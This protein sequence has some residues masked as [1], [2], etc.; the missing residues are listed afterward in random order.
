L[1]KKDDHQVKKLKGFL[2]QATSYTQWAEIAQNLD[3]IEKKDH[4]KSDP[5]SDIYNHE[6]LSARLHE[7][8]NFRLAGQIEDLSR[9]LREGLHHDLGNMGDS[10]LYQECYLGT[11]H[12]IDDYVAEVC[13]CLTYV[14]NNHKSTM[15]PAQK[16]D[17]FKTILLSFGRPALLMSGGASLG[18]FH[19][20]VV[21]ALW[22]RDLLPQVIAG[23]S[24][25]SII[26]AALGT[27]TDDEL[28]E[29]FDP[30]Q[31]SLKPWKW[32]GIASGLSGRGF[33]DQQQLKETIRNFIGDY[34]M[35]EAF[36]RTG[37]SINITVSPVQHH[38]KER[39]LSGYTSPYLLVW[40]AALASCAV[41]TIFPPV[42]LQKKDKDGHMAAYM[43][44]LRWV[45]GSVVSDLPI[46]RLMHLY[47]V[48]FSIVSQTNPHV[49]PFL[50]SGQKDKEHTSWRQLPMQALK[51]ELQFH[52]EGVFDYLRRNA[53]SQLVRQASGQL[54]SVLSQRYM[55]DITVAPHYKLKHYA[56][57]LS[58]PS[59]D[60]I[61]ELMLQGERATW[62]KLAM[63]NTHAKISNTLETC[64]ADLKMSVRS[65]RAKLS[66]IA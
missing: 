57:I 6:M 1:F 50:K 64:I 5:Y 28:P 20:G 18:A 47:D 41:P 46:E 31:L 48:N 52:G 25:G 43:P 56:S 63:I 21:K 49:V 54:H 12:L 24:A 33:M 26:A 40:S 13:E 10:R 59:S 30:E 17:F 42:K 34:T 53:D 61:S 19:L 7:L 62:P 15:L 29:L 66:V 45:D 22:E 65:H 27:H 11:K 4:W 14:C 51:A 60:F 2:A 3:H 38:Q 35:Q 8:R 16:I 39:L 55:G 36:E 32:A 58:N 44:G 9:A 37:R 23:S